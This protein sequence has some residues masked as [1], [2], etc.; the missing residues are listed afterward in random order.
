[1]SAAGGR[2]VLVTGASS[3]FGSCGAAHLAERGYRVY[4]ALRRA[5]TAPGATPLLL[6]VT[7]DASVAQVIQ[8][9]ERLANDTPPSAKPKGHTSTRKTVNGIALRPGDEIRI[10]A[11]SQGSNRAGIDYVEIR[12]QS[13]G[14][15]R[16]P[17][18]TISF[19]IHP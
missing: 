5:T 16:M 4:G 12:P 11:T 17:V 18:R 2:I 3:G 10:E 8:I 13:D 14:L 7:N 1:M 15:A 9:A 19:E 6:D